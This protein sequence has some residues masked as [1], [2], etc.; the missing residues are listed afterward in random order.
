MPVLRPRW[1]PLR[2]GKDLALANK[3]SLVTGGALVTDAVRRRRTSSCCR[4]TASTRPFFSA[5]RTS[6]RPNGCR[7]YC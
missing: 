6:T 2:A 7:K 3:E 1:P 5:C 4:W